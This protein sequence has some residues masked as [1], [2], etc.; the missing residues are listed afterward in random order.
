MEQAAP[1]AS[2][3]SLVDVLTVTGLIV[4]VIGGALGA[5]SILVTWKLYQAG[6]RVNI[7]TLKLLAQ[8]DKA[9]HTTEVT[10]TRFT[11]RMVNTLID[12]VARDVRANVAL[13]STEVAKR[14]ESTLDQSLAGVDPAIAEE[15]KRSVLAE[16]S[17]TF[18]MLQSAVEESI[19]EGREAATA[20]SSVRGLMV[21]ALPRVISWLE[22]NEKNFEF[23]SVKFLREKLFASDPIAQEA[24]QS[25]IDQKLVALY[26]V[27]NPKNPEHPVTACKLNR[28]HPLVRQILREPETG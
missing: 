3:L 1:A 4:S 6:N 18:R 11:E 16:L 12:L 15:A 17:D 5:F 8:V 14:V 23:Y 21:P 10:S 22:K 19:P 24:L 28:E 20:G 25:A 13:S 27:P 2:Q 7:E 26:Q 9:T